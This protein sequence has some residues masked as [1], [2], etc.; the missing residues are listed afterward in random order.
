MHVSK[1][2]SNKKVLR[3]RKRHTARRVAI[4]SPCYS[5]RGGG[6]PQPKIFFPVW[7]CIKPNLVSKIFL[8]T[9]WGGGPLDKKIFFP[10]WTCIKPNLVSKFFPFTVGGAGGVPWQKKIFPGWT[11]IK[12]NLV[13]KIFLFTGWGGGPSTKI[14]FP[15]WTC[16]KPNLVSKFFP[17]TSWGGGVPLQKI[18]FPVWTCIKPNLVSKFFPFTVRGGGGPLTKKI[19]FQA[20]HVSSQIWCQNFF[21]LLVGGGG[22]GGPSTKNFF[23]SL[24]MYQAKSAVKNFPLYWDRV[25]PPSPQVWID[26]QS[27]NITFRHPSDAGGNKAISKGTHFTR[28]LTIFVISASLLPF[29]RE[30]HFRLQT[31]YKHGSK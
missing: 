17:F 24:N 16:I 28:H 19:F 20:D 6:V 3:E 4:V 2:L 18:F 15:V 12:P 7:T 26:T 23:P 13:S 5:E 10:V 9:G 30:V 1:I 25:P 22:G 27:E 29:A 14:F 11:C 8:F 31:K 21:P